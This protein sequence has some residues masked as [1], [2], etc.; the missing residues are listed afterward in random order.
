MA[1]AAKPRSRDD[2]HRLAKA[3]NVADSMQNGAHQRMKSLR[4]TKLPVMAV[5]VLLT[6]SLSLANAQTTEDHPKPVHHKGHPAT[7]HDA[8]K[9]GQHD[10]PRV[11][12]PET[13]KPAHHSTKKAKKR[14]PRGPQAIDSSRAREIQEA[15]VREH[16]MTGKPSGTWDSAT[17]D[18]LR[19]FQAAQGWQS[20]T[21]PDSRALIRLGLGPDHQ[22]L[23]NP[24]SAMTSEPRLPHPSP[25]ATA[26]SSSPSPSSS[27]SVQA[28]PGT[29]AIAVPADVTPS[30]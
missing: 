28:A 5:T 20:K 25:S 29:R 7:H 18:A 6:A 4:S 3:A 19:R 9:A 8:P 16:Y 17:Q 10:D 30:R 14:R 22:H 27:V 11:A 26:R 13:P 24:E 1:L 23:L 15:L 21:V 12:H 2:G